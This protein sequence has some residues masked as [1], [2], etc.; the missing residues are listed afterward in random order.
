M[1]ESSPIRV[2]PVAEVPFEAALRSHRA[3]IAGLTPG[4]E[5]VHVG[6]TALPGALTKGDLDLMV[7]VGAGGFEPAVRALGSAYSI[8]QPEN[9]T[10]SFASFVDPQAS[11]PPVGVQLVVAGSKE[12]AIF[13]PFLEALRDHPALLA[14]YNTL[15]R[16]LDG[17]D[18]ELYTRVKGEFIER[19]LGER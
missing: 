6:S 1:P 8:H 19:V 14:E 16:R 17:S 3:R 13:E 5:V 11:D 12:E 10:P 7:R 9:W 18:Y 4:A 2:R 15:K